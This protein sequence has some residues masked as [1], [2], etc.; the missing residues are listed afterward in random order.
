[1]RN[2]HLFLF[3]FLQKGKS[4]FQSF[5]VV[6]EKLMLASTFCF[7]TENTRHKI[8]SF[9][10]MRTALVAPQLFL[11]RPCKIIETDFTTA[12]LGWTSEGKSV[13]YLQLAYSVSSSEI[14]KDWKMYLMIT[15]I[16]IYGIPALPGGEQYCHTSVDVG[17]FTRRCMA[18][19]ATG[20]WAH[21]LTTQLRWAMWSPTTPKHLH[22]TW[23]C[24]GETVPKHPSCLL[25]LHT[26]TQACTHV[27][28][29]AHSYTG[30]HADTDV[31]PRWV[32]WQPTHACTRLT[33]TSHF[34]WCGKQGKQRERQFIHFLLWLAPAHT[35]GNCGWGN[36]ICMLA[37]M[38]DILTWVV[39]SLV[40]AVLQQ[41]FNM[42]WELT[43]SGAP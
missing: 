20:A 34:I 27:R 31:S 23:P 3:F 8:W 10:N 17:G 39:N 11:T 22:N 13:S 18:L 12:F 19:K 7:I 35:Q 24:S 30:V 29:R 26:R 1:M 33:Y 9:V 42:M 15:S 37:L 43:K 36:F 28:R 16:V 32:L 2:G 40:T 14:W 5:L 21:A 25:H 38:S 6:S 4:V 41:I